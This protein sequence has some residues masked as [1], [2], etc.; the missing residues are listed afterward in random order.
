MGQFLR[1]SDYQMNGRHTHDANGTPPAGSRRGSNIRE[2]SQLDAT[3]IGTVL[4]GDP[5]ESRLRALKEDQGAEEEAERERFERERDLIDAGISRNEAEIKRVDA[6]VARRGAEQ[7]A[8]LKRL[9][10]EEERLKAT[11]IAIAEK[12]GKY[13][14]RGRDTLFSRSSDDASSRRLLM[15]SISKGS[16]SATGR[17]VTSGGWPES[18]KNVYRAPFVGPSSRARLPSS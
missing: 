9:E 5:A 11:E 12:S 18:T 14:R 1:S 16:P 2:R 7:K 13:L 17:S 3:F 6:S 8:L 4:G 10:E 15:N